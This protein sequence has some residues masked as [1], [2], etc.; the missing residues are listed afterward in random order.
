MAV[1]EMT[2][3]TYGTLLFQ[4]EMRTADPSRSSLRWWGS[5]KKSTEVSMQQFRFS[6]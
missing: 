6:L 3:I 4:A 1:Y 5:E 2:V